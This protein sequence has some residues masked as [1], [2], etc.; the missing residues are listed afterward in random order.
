MQCLNKESFAVSITTD[1]RNT[2][3]LQPIDDIMP[4]TQTTPLSQALAH[5]S[6]LAGT[7]VLICVGVKVSNELVNGKQ[8]IQLICIDPQQTPDNRFYNIVVTTLGSFHKSMIQLI[9]G[10]TTILVAN[11]KIYTDKEGHSELQLG[12]KANSLRIVPPKDDPILAKFSKQLKSKQHLDVKQKFIMLS[13]PDIKFD[14]IGKF[15]EFI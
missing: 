14:D 6:H 8:K 7:R 2:D 12:Y 1:S 11:A 10:T 5:V 15:V 9:Y 13:T 3:N 4:P